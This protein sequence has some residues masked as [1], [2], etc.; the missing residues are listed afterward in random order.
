MVAQFMLHHPQWG[1]NTQ[2]V[3]AGRSFHNQRIERLW[4]DLYSNCNLFFYNFLNFL[5][6]LLY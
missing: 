5:R 1:P 6:F 3:I 4:R 2:S